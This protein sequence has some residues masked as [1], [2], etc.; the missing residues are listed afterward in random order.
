M[1]R[2]YAYLMMIRVVKGDGRYS[3]SRVIGT[4]RSVA[5]ALKSAQAF[6]KKLREPVTVWDMTPRSWCTAQALNVIYPR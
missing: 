4:Y 1:R 5:E 6:A 3:A 2:D